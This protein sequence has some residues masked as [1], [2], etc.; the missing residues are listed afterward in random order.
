M[1]NESTPLADWPNGELDD[2]TVDSIERA[3]HVQGEFG[4]NC[5]DLGG[6][7]SVH[8][9]PPDIASIATP[10]RR[11]RV[12]QILKAAHANN[13][14]VICFPAGVLSWGFDEI[15][16]HDPAVRTDNPRLMNPLREESWRWQYKVFDYMLDNFEIDGIHLESADLDR[17]RTK[18][19]LEQ[20]PN[21]VAYHTY[22]TKRTAEYLRR[23]RP[24]ITLL[25]SVQNF[26]KWGRDFTDDE[27]SMLV[28][29]SRSVDCI[30]DQGHAQ[31][32]IPQSRR[33]EFIAKLQCGYGTSGG[34]WVYP[35]QRWE[36][37][38]W[39]LPYTSRTGAHIKQLHQDGGQGVMYYQGPVANP[40]TE[41][42][43]A[44]GGRIMTDPAKDAESVLSEVIETL[45]RPRK[46][47]AREGLVSIF[48]R[49]E[50]GYFENWN[51]DRIRAARKRPEPGELYLTRLHGTS[52]SEASYLL[53]PYLDTNG[54]LAYKRTLV[55]LLQDLHGIEGQFDDD[56]RLA[57][58][59]K[60]IE[61]AL[62]DI[63]N[64]AFAKGETSVWEDRNVGCL[65]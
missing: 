22:V 1:R 62:V 19:C 39:F 17:C 11:R 12:E 5:I 52:P 54:R 55:C 31:T 35:P 32:Y 41:V 59:K 20:W 56:G 10:G 23:K 51:L 9:W 45:Y 34:I 43:I 27:K 65:P 60:G 26:S 15:I 25:A 33:R 13:M 37:G 4:Y 42:N 50:D 36:R 8:A 58:I 7:L 29:L 61:G 53:E 14:K 44:F 21:N 48:R 46:K 30:F 49:A 63:N 40:G 64:I 2:E 57:R 24:E 28:D 6:L 16:K 38:R 18:E 47:A 3:L